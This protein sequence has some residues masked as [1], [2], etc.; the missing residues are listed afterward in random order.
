VNGVIEANNQATTG[1]LHKIHSAIAYHFQT[2]NSYFQEKK[3]SLSCLITRVYLSK[4][5]F[6][7][8]NEVNDA[9]YNR[10][11]FG[12]SSVFFRFGISRNTLKVYQHDRR[13][14]EERPKSWHFFLR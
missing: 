12:E 1:S 6:A 3:P 9:R 14:T 4:V 13:T 5:R 2:I 10:T 8:R 7:V 11:F